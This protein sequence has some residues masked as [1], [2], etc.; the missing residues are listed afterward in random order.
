MA[1]K[2]LLEEDKFDF[3]IE[4]NGGIDFSK[5]EI[6]DISCKEIKD[7]GTLDIELIKEII[8]DYNNCGDNNE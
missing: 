1:V 8:G 5:I 2:L 6:I 3:S 4:E 7:D